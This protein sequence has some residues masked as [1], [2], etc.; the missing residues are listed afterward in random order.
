MKRFLI[1]GL[2]LLIGSVNATTQTDITRDGVESWFWSNITA[3]KIAATIRD[4]EDTTAANSLL[5]TE[6]GKT[7]FLNSTTEFATTLPAPQAGCSFQF[8]VKAAPSGASYTVLTSGGSNL[9]DGVV[10]VNGASVAC[11]DEDTLTFTDGAAV[12]GDMVSLYSDGTNWYVSGAA[13]AAT[14][15]ACSAT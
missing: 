9:I 15:V 2:F 4:Y 14:G 3:N 12:S 8:I 6:C 5:Y 13:T 7:I 1:A 11:A 10:V